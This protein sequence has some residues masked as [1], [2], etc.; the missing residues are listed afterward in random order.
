[1][2]YLNLVDGFVYKDPVFRAKLDA[3]AENDSYL[4][5]NG[6][7]DSTKILFYQAAVPTGWTKITTQNDKFLRVVS[8]TGGGSGGSKAP[9]STIALAHLHVLTTEGT[10]THLLNAHSHSCKFGSA[11]KGENTNDYIV[12]TGNAD[13]RSWTNLGHTST[14]TPNRDKTKTTVNSDAGT[15]A[16]GGHVHTLVSTLTDTTFA[17]CDV[18]VGSKDTGGGTYTDLTTYFHSGDKIDFDPFVTMATNDAYLYARLMPAS[19]IVIFGQASAPLGWT[20]IASTNDKALRIVSGTGAGSGGTTALS[21][22]L[23]LAHTHSMDTQGS[24]SHTSG[25]H[26]H[27]MDTEASL[28]QS[29]A[30]INGNGTYV[31]PKGTGNAMTISDGTAVSRTIARGRTATDGSGV[32]SSTDGAHTHSIVTGLS[33]VT[34][35]YVAIIQCSKDSTGAPQVYADVTSGVF[36]WKK[37]VSKQKLNKLAKNDEYILFH[38]MESGASSFFFMSTVPITWTK[39]VTQ[40]DKALRIVSGSS[41]GSAGGGAQAMSAAV[42]LAHT[43][44][45]VAASHTHTIAHAHASDTRVESSAGNDISV[46]GNPKIVLSVPVG[47]GANNALLGGSNGT[48]RVSIAQDFNSTTA[49]TDSYSHDHGGVT[50]TNL[51]DITF[52]YA[53]VLY[54]EKD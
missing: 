17:Y 20:K 16:A 14:V 29:L 11:V 21:A 38:T 35:A 48:G 15:A 24:H 50:T 10:H 25:V 31:I 3:L 26:T 45:V 27:D 33:N 49:T 41:G 36:G 44:V 4:K 13:L 54:A 51:N 32:S 23:T 47:S 9:S 18:I 46:A 53:D 22:G 12:G 52:A 40:D 30:Q 42:S 1:M 39:I 43:H 2:G 28:S 19:A 34:L 5:D 8:S 7:N 6:W 37:L